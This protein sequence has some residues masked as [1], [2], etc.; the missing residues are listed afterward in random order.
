MQM[1]R[2][3]SSNYP[4][5]MTADSD[6]GGWRVINPTTG[7]RKRFQNEAKARAAALKLNEWL[8]AERQTEA[9]ADGRPTI[10][11]LVA[12]W[13]EERMPHMPWDDGTRRNAEYMLARI[14]RDF[15]S[16]IIARTDCMDL[17]NWM[18]RFCK[19]A[20]QWNKWRYI[21]VLLWKLAISRKLATSNEPEKIETRSTSK[22]IAANR[23]VRQKLDVAGF[24]AIHEEAPP[25][26]QVAMEQ[27]LVTLQARKEICNTR[28]SDYRDGWLYVIRDKVSGESEMG[29]IKIAITAELE[30]IRSGSLRDGV[31]STFLVHRAPAR[32]QRRW[33]RNKPHW[34]AVNAEYLSKAFAEARE[35]CGIYAHLEPPKRPTFHEIRGLGGRIYESQGTPPADIQALM[36]HAHRRTTQIYLEK[37]VAGLTDADYHPVT[38]SGTV[39]QMLRV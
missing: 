29:F 12:K 22:K 20:D 21:L 25:W 26:L 10:S 32:R 6:G 16:R 14:G 19:N 35:A 3:K 33:M 1:G 39:A 28:Y 5:Y 13:R 18:A 8:E 34:T 11:T 31:L 37:G 15:G 23:K 4:K 38:A 30:N 24:K 9:W 36:T 7:K 2:P 17:E 27:S